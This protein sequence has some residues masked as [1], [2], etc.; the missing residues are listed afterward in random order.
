MENIVLKPGQTVRHF[1][2]GINNDPAN[3]VWVNKSGALLADGLITLE[4][5]AEF[6]GAFE[7]FAQ[8]AEQA[9]PRYFR[10]T[11]LCEDIEGGVRCLRRISNRD[12]IVPA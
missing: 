8:T 2:G 11:W 7:A 10:Q 4:P 3:G 6:T 9:Y 5:G 12:I 1:G